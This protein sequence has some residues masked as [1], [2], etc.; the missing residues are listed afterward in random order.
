MAQGED[1]IGVV[2]RGDYVPD[3]GN[4]VDPNANLKGLPESSDGSAS[5]S[6]LPVEDGGVQNE[7]TKDPLPELPKGP[8]NVARMALEISNKDKYEQIAG[9]ASAD[10]WA[11]AADSNLEDAT[12]KAESSDDPAVEWDKVHRERVAQKNAELIE[13]RFQDIVGRIPREKLEKMSALEFVEAEKEFRELDSR[14][15]ELSNITKEL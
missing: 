13:S 11:S 14:I 5:S 7:L 9:M 8:S 4:N 15:T 2:F 3:G 6:D 12:K 1:G 10:E